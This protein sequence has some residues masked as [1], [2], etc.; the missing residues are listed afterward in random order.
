[1]KKIKRIIMF[2]IIVLTVVL[3]V[4]YWKYINTPSSHQI[5]GNSPSQAG[6]STVQADFKKTKPEVTSELAFLLSYVEGVAKD[7]YAENWVMVDDKVPF[8]ESYWIVVKP[9]LINLDLKKNTIESINLLV[10]DLKSS[11]SSRNQYGVIV[12]ANAALNHFA[13]ALDLYKTKYPANTIRLQCLAR[14][15]E[16]SAHNRKWSEVDKSLKEMKALWKKLQSTLDKNTFSSDIKAIEKSIAELERYTKARNRRNVSNQIKALINTI[17]S[18][19][20]NKK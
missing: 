19:K 10:E 15:T 11:A 5:V 17:D 7:A 8:I 2:L 4:S 6:T 14:Q 13:D 12:N 1:M 3:V 16:I 20:S 9:S 18:F